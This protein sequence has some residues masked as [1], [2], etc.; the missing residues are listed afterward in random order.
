MICGTRV[1]AAWVERGVP[2]HFVSKALGHSD[3]AITA[4]YVHAADADL[5]A[6]FA[7][8]GAARNGE[9]ATGSS[10]R[11]R[12]TQLPSGNRR[13]DDPVGKSRDSKGFLRCGSGDLNPDPL[14]R[15]SS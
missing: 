1:R 11:T 3:I 15:T 2:I 10:N 14:A 7:F 4:I 12:D 6:G 5:K 8:G 9:V 13:H